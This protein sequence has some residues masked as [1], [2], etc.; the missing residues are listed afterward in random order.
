MTG[1][2]LRAARRFNGLTQSQLA[3]RLGVGRSVISRA[4]IAGEKPVAM[5]SSLLDKAI[6]AAGNGVEATPAAPAEPP[7]EV[8]RKPMRRARR[9]AGGR[10]SRQLAIPARART[11]LIVELDDDQVALL[12]EICAAY[13]ELDADRVGQVRPPTRH[14]VIRLIFAEA[15]LQNPRRLASYLFAFNRGT[16]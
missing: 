8:A 5:T 15:L 11:Q 9:D 3:A 4:E 7:A 10:T 13:Q 6:R 14:Q 2:E 16:R 1:A 12:D